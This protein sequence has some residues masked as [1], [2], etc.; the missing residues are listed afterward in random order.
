MLK[1]GVLAPFNAQV[2]IY[3]LVTNFKNT[4]IFCTVV[5]NFG[6]DG[7][8]NVKTRWKYFTIY[9]LIK[10]QCCFM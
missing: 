2:S 7:T 3:Q 4:R 5:Q 10:P 6:A 8:H 1:R 9:W